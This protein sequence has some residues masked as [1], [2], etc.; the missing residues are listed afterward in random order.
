MAR[1]TQKFIDAFLY[2]KML[3]AVRPL[4]EV[5]MALDPSEVELVSRIKRL[6]QEITSVEI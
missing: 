1:V 6:I 2:S 4:N 3:D 5:L